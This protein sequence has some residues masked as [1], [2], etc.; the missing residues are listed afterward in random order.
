MITSLEQAVP[1]SR[2]SDTARQQR[3]F[4]QFLKILRRYAAVFGFFESLYCHSLLDTAVTR[5]KGVRQ[6]L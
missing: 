6:T 4:I 2:G 1:T 3:A 5:H